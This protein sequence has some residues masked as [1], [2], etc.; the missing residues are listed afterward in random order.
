MPAASAGDPLIVEATTGTPQRESTSTPIPTY[1][2]FCASS[3]STVDSGSRNPLCPSSPIAAT[4]PFRSEGDAA[5]GID[6]HANPDIFGF[7]RLLHLHGRLRIEEPT[8]SFVTDC[9]D[10]PL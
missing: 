7:L 3:I 5:T 10:H 2:A 9:G 8:V 4:I 1:S 6:L